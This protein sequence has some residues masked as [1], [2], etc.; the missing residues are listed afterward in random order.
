MLRNERFSQT[1]NSC[2]AFRAAKHYFHNNNENVKQKA[3]R[4]PRVRQINIFSDKE[5]KLLL[6]SQIQFFSLFVGKIVHQS[7]DLHLLPKNSKLMQSCNIS[8]H[9]FSQSACPCNFIKN[10][11]ANLTASIA[12]KCN[13]YKLHKPKQSNFLSKDWEMVIFNQKLPILFFTPTICTW[14]TW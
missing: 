14:P 13:F 8:L 7:T 12:L 10:K 2:C 5:I 9:I 1:N 4:S 11:T 6:S 3:D